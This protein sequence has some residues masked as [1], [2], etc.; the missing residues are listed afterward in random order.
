ML[1]Y[2]EALSVPNE[3][4][5]WASTLPSSTHLICRNWLVVA[6]LG[7]WVMTRFLRF[8]EA[9][10]ARII[11]FRHYSMTCQAFRPWLLLDLND[12]WQKWSKLIRISSMRVWKRRF[13]T[14]QL[15]T[16]DE[17]REK[18]PKELPRRLFLDLVTY[19]HSNGAQL[20]WRLTP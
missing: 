14:C 2:Y 9:F 19:M 1:N 18:F 6:T 20:L 3:N 5:P 10:D 8:I 15:T 13:C 7:N 11:L 12:G 16:P 17:M 4:F